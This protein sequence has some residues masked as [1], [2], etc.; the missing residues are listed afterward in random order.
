M[1]TTVGTM[2]AVA[3]LGSAILGWGVAFVVLIVL[4]VLWE[5]LASWVATAS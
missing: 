2:L 3:A 4:A 5:G 1:P